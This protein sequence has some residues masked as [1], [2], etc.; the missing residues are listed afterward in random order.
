MSMRQNVSRR[1]LGAIFVVTVM[2]VAT[3]AAVVQLPHIELQNDLETWLAD[4]DEQAQAL[5]KMQQYFPKEEKMLVSWDTSSLTDVR[6]AA[7]RDRLEGST[8]ISEVK[9]AADVLA[10]MVDL[11]IDEQEARRRLTG[12]LIGP[13][14]T[15]EVGAAE[16][17][18]HAEAAN[19]HEPCVSAVLTLSEAGIADT[20]AAL[21]EVKAAAIA[22][23]IGAEELHVDGSLVTSLAVDRE[24]QLSTWN[25]VDPWQ[26]PPVFAI[27]AMFGFLL[28]FAVLR[29]VRL[30]LMVIISGWFTALVST[31]LFP[32]SGH[33]MNMVTI[34][35]PTLMVVLTI[36]AAIHVA[37]YWK[38]A[39]ATGAA[40]P[41][42]EA[43][44][45]GW[46]PC[47]M[48]TVTTCVGLASLAISRLGPIRDFGVFSTIGV[49]L[50]LL[51][52]VV[53]FP[54]M[55]RLSNV[56][57][58]KM[59]ADSPAWEGVAR[60][61][62][63]FRKHV[64]IAFL[65][66]FV[67]MSFGLRWLRT[68]VKVGR[69]FPEDSQLIQDSRF[70]ETYIGGTSSV[71]VLIHFG[72]DY[73]EKR[74]FLERLELIRQVE[75]TLR[76]H[77]N[78]TGAISL[79]DFQPEVQSPDKAEGRDARLRYLMRNRQVEARIKVD[80][81]ESSSEYLAIGN[82]PETEWSMGADC[83]ETWR[84]TAQS[85]LSDDLDY[86]SFTTELSDIVRQQLGTPAGTWFEVTGSVPV[87]YRAQAALLESL[88]RSLGLAFIVISITMIVLLRSAS[89]GLISSIPGILPIG[90][91]FGL[92]SWMGYVL[93]IG[94]ML[95]G[96]VAVGIAVD[97]ILHLLTWF[98]A[99]IR[100][101]KSREESVVLALRHCGTAMTQTTLVIALSLLLL[102]PADLLLIS[103]FGWVMAALLGMAWLS[104]VVLLPALL[105]GPLGR[106]IETVESRSHSL[107]FCKSS[108]SQENKT[109]QRSALAG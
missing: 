40:D 6:S 17:R 64:I 98:R 10:R 31:S 7:F 58:G 69:Y 72:K 63:R 18:E 96:S 61:V 71:D 8:Y 106:I 11:K 29:S 23:G 86:G 62:C 32:A 78:I 67:S 93:D 39:A 108:S 20:A 80:E 60:I 42:R 74:W 5:R 56:L 22:C 95:T 24:V 81:R 16:T 25:T 97:D 1:T 2:M 21:D 85:A 73:T 45:M 49:L 9:T 65:L 48:A 41:I 13:N 76:K 82:D 104:S 14:V 38:Y 36:S 75:E 43:I 15:A 84:I 109:N 27:S 33:T 91:V 102:Y 103:R 19:S 77:S 30:G 89:A 88:I 44:R 46:Q 68:E 3:I 105:A 90:L 26:R 94:T 92:M 79:A 54:A 87:F 37:N 52:V 55:I 70:M 100:D 57:P 12:L 83:D 34:V 107:P 99:S 101:G 35:M 53:G 4:D 47:L 66:I 50:S 51:V 59:E 28:A